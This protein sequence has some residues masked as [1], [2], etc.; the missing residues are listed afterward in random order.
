VG[1]VSSSDREEDPHPVYAINSIGKMMPSE[2]D[3][4]TRVTFQ[5]SWLVNVPNGRANT[6]WRCIIPEWT[7]GGAPHG[8]ILLAL[9]VSATEAHLQKCEFGKSEALAMSALFITVSLTNQPAFVDVSDIKVGKGRWA[10]LEAKLKQVQNGVETIILTANVTYGKPKTEKDSID[11][12]EYS[13][14]EPPSMPEW[15]NGK[16]DKDWF[17][18]FVAPPMFKSKDGKNM[19]DYVK[20]WIHVSEFNAGGHEARNA[21]VPDAWVALQDEVVSKKGYVNSEAM[22]LFTCKFADSRL[23]HD[24]KSLAFFCDLVT[25]PLLN[26]PTF[27]W[28]NIRPWF[29]TMH[30]L[31]DFRSFEP[32]EFVVVKSSSSVMSKGKSD[33]ETVVFDSRG[34]CMV[35][36]RQNTLV[37]PFSKNVRK[38]K[39]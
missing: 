28:R 22:R 19:N 5:E 10:H 7:I 18:G 35:L 6:R 11:E 20:K 14:L 36:S 17:E 31:V 27:D 16:P 9:L 26:N 4:A 38:S 2:F 25:P 12:L 13:A 33:T 23:I 32:T 1:L 8:G 3:R 34:R 30:I 15:T 21:V 24:A 39:L 29:P 37:V